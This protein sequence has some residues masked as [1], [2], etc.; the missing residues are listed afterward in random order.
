MLSL[1][2]WIWQLPQHTIALIVR[3]ILKPESLEHYKGCKVYWV[4]QKYVGVSLGQYIFVSTHYQ[5]PTVMHEYG[6][7]V[8]SLWL[9]PLYIL[10]IS[11]PSFLFCYARDR[12]FHNGWEMEK[13]IQWY[14]R[15]P[16]E[17][18]ADKLGGVDRV[19]Y[20]YE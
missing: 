7:S 2:L 12:L 13:R 11:I 14:Y 5:R 4:K 8:Q 20:P 15:Q 1:L 18:L 10:L 19:K 17:W 16:T 6:H 9:G 3:R